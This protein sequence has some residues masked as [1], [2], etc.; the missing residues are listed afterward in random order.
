[1]LLVLFEIISRVGAIKSKYSGGSNTEHSNSESIR[2]PN[3]L[4]VGDR[5]VQTIRKPN[6]YLSITEHFK[7]AALD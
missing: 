4:K 5:M 3:I 6:F 7:M 2:K 1:M